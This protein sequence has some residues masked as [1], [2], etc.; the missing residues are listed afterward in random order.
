[1]NSQATMSFGAPD[2][3]DSRKAV[4]EYWESHTMGTQF[5]RDDRSV[6]PGTRE[7]FERLH[8]IMFR[9]EYLLPLISRESEHLKGR[10]LLEIGCGMGFDS[11][12]WKKRGV[13][14]TS[15]DLTQ[16]AVDSAKIHFGV[17][18]Q[19]GNFLVGSALDLPVPDNSYDAI[20]SRGVLHVTS[21]TQRAVSE[22]YRV[23]KPGG[24]LIVVNLYNRYSWFVLLHKLGRENFEF[25]EEDAPMI[26]L[27]RKR[28]IAELFSAF[29]GLEIRIEHTYP[30]KTKRKGVKSWLF[31]QVFYPM[32]RAIPRAIARPFGFK[33]VITANKPRS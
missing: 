12:E 22:A 11:L 23:L 1:M 26:D 13:D 33:F 16:S 15:L 7:F 28:E 19:A 3:R 29:E 31:N 2:T 25:K 5:L 8:P 18:G 24:R 27:Y 30:Y 10:R 14:V 17:M 9:H 6:E 20:Y 4:R 32:Y 21:D